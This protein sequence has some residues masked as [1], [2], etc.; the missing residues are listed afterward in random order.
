MD[1][2]EIYVWLCYALF[3]IVGLVIFVGISSYIRNKLHICEEEHNKIYRHEK[4]ESKNNNKPETTTE[5]FKKESFS[6]FSL[7]SN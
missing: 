6:L 5:D 2:I 3:V 4:E 1:K 7:L